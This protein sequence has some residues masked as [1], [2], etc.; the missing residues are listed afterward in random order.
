M[1]CSRFVIVKKSG[2]EC[3]LASTAIP[4]LALELAEL[5]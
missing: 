2:R 3:S 1:W 5:K 4:K